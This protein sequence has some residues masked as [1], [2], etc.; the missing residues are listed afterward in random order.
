MNRIKKLSIRIR[1]RLIHSYRLQLTLYILLFFLV[2]IAYVLIFWYYYPIYEGQDVSLMKSLLFVMET[3]TTVGYGE[4]VPFKTDQMAFVAIVIMAS[5]IVAFFGIINILITP[6]IQARIQPTPPQKLPFT[7]HKHVIIFGY[8]QVIQEVID[9]LKAIGTT[10]VLIEEDQHRAL[11]LA[12]RMAQGIHVIWGDYHK[13]KTWD[14]A[15]VSHAGYII[16]FL[17]ERISARVTLG[18]KQHSSAE[19][20]AVITDTSL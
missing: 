10:V 8:S 17:E 19:I 3:I 9:N 1:T 2:I 4:F 11:Q 12:A 20:I 14:A 15:G 7:P 16:L 5:G 18:I 13:E 6:M